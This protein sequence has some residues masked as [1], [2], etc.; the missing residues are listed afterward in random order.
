MGDSNKY[1][2][3]YEKTF[4][5]P[6]PHYALLVGLDGKNQTVALLDPNTWKIN[7]IP[8]QLQ[9]EQF[10]LQKQHQWALFHF[11]KK[12]WLMKPRTALYLQE[13]S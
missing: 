7:D 11:A 6:Y 5:Y 9:R 10:D 3:K 4:T 12:I 13:I 1:L 2:W 8:F